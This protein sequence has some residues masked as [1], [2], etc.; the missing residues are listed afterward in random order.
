MEKSIYNIYIKYYL[1][2][3]R[4]NETK[5]F[6]YSFTFTLPSYK[7]YK[8]KLK[9]LHFS[10]SGECSNTLILLIVPTAVVVVVVVVVVSLAV[11]VVVVVVVVSLAG[12]VVMQ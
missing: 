10:R 5:R 1:Q 6:F 2:L 9:K 11:V 12:V 4:R 7:I 8:I 3:N